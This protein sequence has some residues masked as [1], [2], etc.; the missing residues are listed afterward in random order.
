MGTSTR[1][2]VYDNEIS[3]EVVTD[4]RFNYNFDTRNGRVGLFGE[5]KRWGVE[6]WGQNLLN[7]RYQQI[8]GLQFH[9]NTVT[10]DMTEY[11]AFG[12]IHG[13]LHLAHQ[14]EHVREEAR[15][16]E[17]VRVDAF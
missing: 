13:N 5:G 7:K 16:Q 11:H 14:R 2:D 10:N 4:L 17:S 6:L 8:T 15:L 3:S 12:E 9:Y 1:W